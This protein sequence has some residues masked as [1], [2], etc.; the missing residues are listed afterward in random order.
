MLDIPPVQRK[1]LLLCYLGV[2]VLGDFEAFVDQQRV[3]I[4]QVLQSASSILSRL[5]SL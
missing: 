2:D 1:D 5:L 3:V 4:K